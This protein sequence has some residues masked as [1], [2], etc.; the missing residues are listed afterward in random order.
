[1]TT[2]DAAETYE[3]LLSPI[4]VRNNRVRNRV[5]VTA[6]GA[7]D[8]FRDPTLRPDS[9]IE[10]LR[11]RAAGGAGLIIAQPLLVNPLVAIPESSVVRHPHQAVAV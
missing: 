3:R 9:Y 7:S 2:D 1:V 11:R 10:Y 6:H 4:T 8:F 5:V